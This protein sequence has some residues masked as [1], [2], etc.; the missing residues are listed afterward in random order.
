MTAEPLLALQDLSVGFRVGGDIFRALDGVSLR[1]PSNRIVG[2]VGE[3][4]SGKSTVALALMGL[5]PSNAT[6]VAGRMTFDGKSY[7]LA[8]RAELERLRGDRITMVFQDPMTALNPVFT[9]GTQL[10][11]AQRRK[12]PGRRVSELKERARSMLGRVGL[13]DTSERLGRYPH[14]LSGGMRQRVVIAMALLVEPHLLIADEATTA[15]DVTIE[16]QIMAEL[17]R[18]RGDIAG[19]IMLVSH[20]LGLVSQICDEVVVLYAGRVVES[21]S[22][23]ELFTA[24]QHP[25]TRALIACEDQA[26]PDTRQFRSIPGSVPRFVDRPQGCM[27][28][29]RCRSAMDRCR[30]ETPPWRGTKDGHGAA[31]WLT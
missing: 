9:I 15:L 23:R 17:E 26:A 31:C 25:Y 19:S 29:A 16:A 21:A 13:T 5:L 2:V 10:V 28:A 22:T 1:I 11:D 3:S 14:E 27:F 24:P 18:L 30:S 4:G 6:S 8:N 20:S 7:D 12:H